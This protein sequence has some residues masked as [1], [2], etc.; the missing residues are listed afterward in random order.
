MRATVPSVL[1]SVLLLRGCYSGPGV[2]HYL[3]ILDTLEIPADW[4]LVATERRG[5][6]EDFACDPLTNSTCP[7]LLDGTR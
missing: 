7:V 1:A 6:G 4:E 3:G 5:P 2:D